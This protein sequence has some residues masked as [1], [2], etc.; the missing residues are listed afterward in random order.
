MAR[1]TAQQATEKWVTR[2]SAAS[3][4]ITDGVNGVTTAPG[5]AAGKAVELWA[6]RVIAAKP[7]WKARVESVSLGDWQRSMIEVGI[8]R[9]S[10]GAQAKKGKVEDFMTQFLPHVDQGVAQVKNMP[11]GDIGASVARAAFMIQWNAKFQRK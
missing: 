10:Q 11:K 2:L 4:Q 1:V 5:L 8:P 7:K 3:Q 6:Q 9:I